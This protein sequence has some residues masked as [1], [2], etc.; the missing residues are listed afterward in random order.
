MTHKLTIT[1][2]L[3][4]ALIACQQQPDVSEDDAT[5]NNEQPGDVYQS[6]GK[7]IL[8][9]VDVKY[10]LLDTP[11]VGQPFSLELTIVSSVATSAIGYKIDA[12]SGLSVDRT[13]LSRNFSDKAAMSPVTTTLTITPLQ[14]GRFY[15]RVSANVLVNGVNKSR[16][17]T[18][19]IQVGEGSRQL[20]QM[21]VVMTDD[22]G[23]PVV[24]LPATEKKE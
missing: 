22:E 6:P 14:E 15:L 20:E 19:P 24:S 21:G 5:A 7:P 4:A 12:E 8:V 16:I 2:F 17:I 10:R 1:A 3:L 9:P 18:I 23:N 11:Q 13:A